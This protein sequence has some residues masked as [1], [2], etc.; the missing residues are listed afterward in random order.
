LT[1]LGL[2][3]NDYC[4]KKK[5]RR[6]TSYDFTIMMHKVLDALWSNIDM[7]YLDVLF[8]YHAFDKLPKTTTDVSHM[9][10]YVTLPRMDNE[11][12]ITILERVSSIDDFLNGCQ[13]YSFDSWPPYA[14]REF[15]LI[16]SLG[17]HP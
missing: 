13:T 2:G 10:K 15:E 1:Y 9:V 4:K 11:K 5:G 7:F 16:R 6:G 8:Y 12:K 3:F 17:K 14:P